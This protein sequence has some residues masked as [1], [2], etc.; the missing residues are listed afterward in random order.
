MELL[1]T[2]NGKKKKKKIAAY[3]PLLVLNR[4]SGFNNRNISL[5]QNVMGTNIFN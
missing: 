1:K 3:T 4:K 2:V 5:L